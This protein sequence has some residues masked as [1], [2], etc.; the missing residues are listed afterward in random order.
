M[1]Y[2]LRG[3]CA[4][5]EHIA[6]PKGPSLYYQL[7]RDSKHAHVMSWNFNKCNLCACTRVVHALAHDDVIIASMHLIGIALI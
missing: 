4:S 2:E 6:P 1:H 3:K 5:H 7:V